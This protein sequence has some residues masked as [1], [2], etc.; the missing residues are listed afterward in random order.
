MFPVLLAERTPAGSPAGIISRN[1]CRPRIA[2]ISSVER[3]DAAR[4]PAIASITRIRPYAVVA[5]FIPARKAGP[6]S[7]PRSTFISPAPRAASVVAMRRGPARPISRL[8]A[9]L[10][11]RVIIRSTSS[12]TGTRW[13]TRE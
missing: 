6:S 10:L 3:R 1:S 2:S 8:V 9:R 7:T 11:D 13:P 12:R 4:P 5:L